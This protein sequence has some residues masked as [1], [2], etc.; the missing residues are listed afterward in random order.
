[1]VAGPVYA[2]LS[3]DKDAGCFNLILVAVPGGVP[4]Q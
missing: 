2:I 4:V 1:M 3:F